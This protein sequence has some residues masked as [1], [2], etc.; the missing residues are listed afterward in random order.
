MLTESEINVL[1]NEEHFA[2]T[3]QNLKAQFQKAAALEEELSY[4][5]F[6]VL[7]MVMPSIS[8][9]LA[10]GKI[11]IFEEISIFRKAQQLSRRKKIE[12]E[13]VLYQALTYLTSN[14]KEW[15]TPF[16]TQIKN[17]LYVS[18]QANPKLWAYIQSEDSV[19]GDYHK[20][21][22]NAPY[23]LLK[24]IKFLFLE[25]EQELVGKHLISRSE[26]ETIQKIG[27]T[28]D[29]HKIPLFQFF[30]ASFDVR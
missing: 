9:A 23:I 2:N 22:L 7:M 16:Y 6:F 1:L 19:T 12:K 20:D 29:L 8:I 27:Q 18:L 30:M 13:D 25:E 10:N 28:I 26:H 4:N 17:I 21:L 3:T 14:F 24:L 15:E 5:D 11:S